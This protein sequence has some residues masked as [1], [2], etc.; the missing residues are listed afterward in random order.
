MKSGLKEVVSQ[1]VLADVKSIN[2]IGRKY[3]NGLK[4]DGIKHTFFR[5]D[6]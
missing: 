4:N 5:G 6:I 3:W 2:E 1:S